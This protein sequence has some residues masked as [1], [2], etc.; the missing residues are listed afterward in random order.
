M[1]KKRTYYDSL[2][3]GHVLLGEQVL[4]QPL[5]VIVGPVHMVLPCPRQL[6]ETRG[7]ACQLSGPGQINRLTA[8]RF[9]IRSDVIKAF[10]KYL[11][12]IIFS[13]FQIQWW[14]SVCLHLSAPQKPWWCE[15]ARWEMM[16][17]LLPLPG[18]RNR[19][20]QNHHSWGGKNTAGRL[21]RLQS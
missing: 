11:K 17:R 7:T 18:V 5:K 3:P 21:P 2:N 15:H 10:S 13:P 20:Y 16:S 8:A 19:S 9:C 12:K 6:A 1:G 14:R 4:L